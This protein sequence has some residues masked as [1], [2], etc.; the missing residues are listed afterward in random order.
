MPLLLTE[1][2][3]DDSGNPNTSGWRARG[4]AADY[5]RW[6]NWFDARMQEDP[7]VVGC[8]L[9]QN[10]D[11]G[12]WWSFELEP[13][14]FWM[15]DYLLPPVAPPPPPGGVSAAA[16]SASIS[17]TWTNAPLSPTGYTIRRATS[18]S[19]PFHTLATDVRTGVRAGTYEDFAVTGN[20]T[21]YYQVSAVNALGESAPSVVVSAALTNPLPDVVITSISWTP[22]VISNGHRVVFSARVLNRGTASTPAG[23]VLGVG[24]N[25]N[26]LGTAS[27]SGSHTTALPPGGSI[28]LTADGGPTGN[29]WTATPGWHTVVA[30]VD[31]VN[32]FPELNESNNALATN[33]FVH[34]PNPVITSYYTSHAHVYLTW[35]T[36]AG[37][38]YALQRSDTLAPGSWT[39]GPTRIAAST[40]MSTTE[41]VGPGQSFF[42][43]HQLD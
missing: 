28:T 19:G 30:T 7:Y 38:S 11:P 42:R 29:Y 36:V 10:G 8:T 23:T 6:L 39:A 24:F 5:Q 13:I 20:T 31:D 1:G 22:S 2:G 43:V 16:G 32:R 15:R 17:V 18:S 25:V 37:R 34:T 21:Y 26:G 9:F 3:V 41:P 33:I 40:N 12:G 35:R 4:S 14:A 27:W